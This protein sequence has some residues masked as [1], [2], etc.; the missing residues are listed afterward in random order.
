MKQLNHKILILTLCVATIGCGNKTTRNVSDNVDTLKNN[1]IADSINDISTEFE[2]Y[3]SHFQK[4]NLPIT[5]YPCGYVSYDS[6]G[7]Y[8]FKNE[9][10]SNYVGDAA[11]YFGDVA[12]TFAQIPTNGN[13]YAI[14]LFYY[15]DCD[16]PTLITYTYDG[17]EI[18]RKAIIT[19]GGSD[20]GYQSSIS[21][22][23]YEDFTIYVA[24]SVVTWEV[25][26]L[27]Q[28]IDGTREAYVNYF[29]GKMLENGK[30]KL[31]KEQRKYTRQNKKNTTADF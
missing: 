8:T 10:F 15:A 13:Y 5:I 21:T 3:L 26:S 14:I 29:T 4:M 17:N 2:K 28:E 7:L 6:L 12:T 11:N 30:I 23:I 16:I 18:D 9:E 24:D 22:R 19:G 20:I 1:I 31:S 25:D 27:N